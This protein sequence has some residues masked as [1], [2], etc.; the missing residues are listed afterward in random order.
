MEGSNHTRNRL[1]SRL[2]TMNDAAR[3]LYP[4]DK[5]YICR[6][7]KK[8]FWTTD[9]SPWLLK[10]ARDAVE[11]GKGKIEETVMPRPQKHA[12]SQRAEYLPA[13]GLVR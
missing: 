1:L 8:W 13:A 10:I 9:E 7:G 2:R 11:K 12:Q 3:Y 5:V 6:V 4:G